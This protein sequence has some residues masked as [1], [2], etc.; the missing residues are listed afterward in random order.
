MCIR[1]RYTDEEKLEALSPLTLDDVKSFARKLYEKV[2]VTGVIHG[3]WT[4]ERAKESVSILLNSLNGQS[5][6]MNER[7]EQVV[8]VLNPGERIQFSREVE[9]NNN[10]LSYI[11]QVG[12]KDL[13]LM[14]KAS[15]LASIVENDFYTQMR[16][17]QQLSL[18][19]I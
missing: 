16:T 12:E 7:Y 11:I 15:I 17:N 8:E 10:S 4:D 9:D 18:I 2:Y 13:A 5:L 1:D 6:P 14:A 3:N 19:H